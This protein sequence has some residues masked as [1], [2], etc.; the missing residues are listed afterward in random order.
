MVDK[1]GK[2][3]IDKSS[4]KIYKVVWMNDRTVLLE[5]YESIQILTSIKILKTYYKPLKTDVSAMTLLSS[6]NT[7]RREIHPDNP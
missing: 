1:Q 7:P 5:G 4:E 6:Q 3:F 2:W